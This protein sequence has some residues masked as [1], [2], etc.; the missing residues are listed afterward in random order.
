[1][2]HLLPIR[3]SRRARHAVLP[4]VIGMVI[5]LVA[6]TVL[7]AMARSPWPLTT[8]LHHWEAAPNCDAA[9]AVGLAPAKRGQP[10][11]WPWL[12]RD[13]NGIACEP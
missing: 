5:G 8:T 6:L 12:D 10:G 4:V 1:M 7:V 13:G 9:R 11:Y 3:R 2:A